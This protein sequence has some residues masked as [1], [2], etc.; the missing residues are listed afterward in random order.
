MSMDWATL[1]RSQQA[2]FLQRLKT[3]SRAKLQPLP[4]LELSVFLGLIISL[5]WVV[6]PGISINKALAAE[7][8]LINKL[9]SPSLEKNPL[10]FFEKVGNFITSGSS[11]LSDNSVVRAS[12]APNL[13]FS[14]TL[15]PTFTPT[16]APTFTPTLV[17]TLAPSLSLMRIDSFFTVQE[18]NLININL[19]DKENTTSSILKLYKDEL[20]SIDLLVKIHKIL[21]TILLS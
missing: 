11:F 6:M 7:A 10:S 3:F 20:H 5:I 8:P 13:A 9:V 1:L 2:D 21:L 15:A 17:P 16:L 12:F 19:G 18:L 14:P 4:K